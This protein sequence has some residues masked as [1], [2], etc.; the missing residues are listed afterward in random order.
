MPGYASEVLPQELRRLVAGGRAELR[1]RE[2]RYEIDLPDR[3]A[4]HALA[5]HEA[6]RL[7]PITTPHHAAWTFDAQ[8]LSLLASL[9]GERTVEEI[10][11]ER[12]GERTRQTLQALARYGLLEPSPVDP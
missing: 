1:L 4:A 5:R 9:D 3:P 11:G 2:P 12:E 7:R 8:S 6:A 10:A